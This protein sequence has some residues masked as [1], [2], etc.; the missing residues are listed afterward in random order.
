MLVVKW[1]L[2]YLMH[3][4]VNREVR[5]CLVNSCWI[6]CFLSLNQR[7]CLPW[8]RLS[9]WCHELFECSAI[10]LKSTVN[11]GQ[12]AFFRF[13]FKFFQAESLKIWEPCDILKW[14]IYTRKNL[15]FHS[16]LFGDVW[17]DPTIFRRVFSLYWVEII[18]VG[19]NIML[20]FQVII[21]APC[22]SVKL[23]VVSYKSP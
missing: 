4:E 18:Y 11:I 1:S 16:Y 19:P 10:Q 21:K 22:I 15:Y 6:S 2:E 12:S 9:L 8:F 3:D 5:E 17:L 20:F 14:L 7:T 23:I 13:I